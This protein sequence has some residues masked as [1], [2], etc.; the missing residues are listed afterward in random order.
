MRRAPDMDNARRIA[1]ISISALLIAVFV[2]APA[3]AASGQPVPTVAIELIVELVTPEVLKVSLMYTCL[4]SPIPL[5]DVTVNVTQSSPLPA[6]GVGGA[7]LICDGANRDVDV[8][9]FGGPAFA[10]GDALATATACTALTCGT[11]S[12]KV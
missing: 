10:P 5:G 4:P 6:Q 7:D 12:R 2:P 3:R 9:V 1:A 11:D 8:M